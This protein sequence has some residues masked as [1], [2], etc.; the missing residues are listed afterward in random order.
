M[1]LITGA[2]GFL[3]SYILKQLVEKG[4]NVRALYRNNKLP[5][6][7]PTYIS[8]N[9]E[10]QNGDVLDVSSLQKATIGV[11]SIIH[12]AGVVSFMRETRK[13]MYD[14]NINGTRNVASIAFEKNVKRF[15]HISSISA[16]GIR[17]DGSY[18]NEN[19]KWE[20]SDLNS[21]YAITKFKGEQEVWKWMSKGLNGVILNPT[22]VLGYGDWNNT[23]CQIFKNV[24]RGFKWFS[25]GINGFVDVEDVARVSQLLIESSIK[26]ERF[27]L[28]SEN[29]SFKKL[30]DT[31]ADGFGKK[32]PDKKA[33]FTMLA[34]AWRLEKM[35]SLFSG[36]KPS[37]TKEIATAAQG[38]TNFK[39]DKVLSALP[40]FSFSPIKQT[41]FKACQNYIS[42]CQKS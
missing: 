23:S 5:F 39:N 40:N 2:S 33:T 30:M 24:Y 28:N 16:V 21:H 35:R 11:D 12:T 1:I 6:Y 37:L 38:A 27:I 19:T 7:I 14:V 36:E 17:A 20:E 29:W 3:G 22:T 18:L 13:I 9:T 32:H 42:D 15:I 41:I 34:I 8:K 25:D 31:I 10:W 4:Y 26:N